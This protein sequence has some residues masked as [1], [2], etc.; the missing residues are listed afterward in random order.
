MEAAWLVRISNCLF[1]TKAFTFFSKGGELSVFFKF[2]PK[3]HMLGDNVFISNTYLT[4]DDTYRTW[5]TC[6]Y[7]QKTSNYI[8]WKYNINGGHCYTKNVYIQNWLCMSIS[9]SDTFRMLF[10]KR[11]IWGTASQDFYLNLEVMIFFVYASWN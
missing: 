5:T 7:W 10:L 6:C 2:M 3:M 9:V 11:F 4:R 1:L 8:W